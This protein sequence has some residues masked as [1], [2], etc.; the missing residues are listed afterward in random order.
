M[1]NLWELLVTDA[2]PMLELPPNSPQAALAHSKMCFE[3]LMRLYYLRHGSEAAN[4]VFV[5][6]LHILSIMSITTLKILSF[7]STSLAAIDDVRATLILAIKCLN[8]QRQNYYMSEK[9]YN[10]IE[11]QL[12][13]KDTE[14]VR[15]FV[16]VR[17]EDSEVR[18]LH[19]KHSQSKIPVDN[20]KITKHPENKLLSNLIQQL[21]DMSQEPTSPA[22]PSDTE[23]SPWVTQRHRR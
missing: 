17:K 22:E 8:D 3:T 10:I 5:H 4:I 20:A 15:K 12:S 18:R 7:H 14:L 21:V 2:D 19:A 23:S 6:Y 11:N 16:H 9:I 13:S 1:L